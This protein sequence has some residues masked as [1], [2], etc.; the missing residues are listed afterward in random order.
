MRKN[1]EIID[2]VGHATDL[3]TQ[4]VTNYFDERAKQKQPFFM[5]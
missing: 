1:K 3:F 5:Y 4:W 2:P